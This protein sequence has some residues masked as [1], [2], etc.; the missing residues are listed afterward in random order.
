[1]RILSLTLLALFFAGCGP[2]VSEAYRKTAQYRYEVGEDA[3]E[4]GNYLEAVTH[5]S[6]VKT[7]FPY[8]KFAAL[9]ELRIGDAYFEQD[10]FVEAIDV[11]QTFVRRRPKHPKLAYAYWRIA[12]GYF[13]QMPADFFLFPPSFE[14]DRIYTKDALAAYVQY[15]SRFPDG[16]YAK[17]AGAKRK[18][19]RTKLGD[20]E[21][22]VARFYLKNER[23]MSAMGRLETVHERFRDIPGHWEEGSLELLNVYRLLSQ[24]DSSGEIRLL[25]AMERARGVAQTLIDNKPG[26]K[27]ASQATRYMAALNRGDDPE[28]VEVYKAKPMPKPPRFKVTK[29]LKEAAEDIK[30]SAKEAVLD[31]LDNT[32]KN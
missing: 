18:F 19:C 9:A 28:A 7:K 6:R 12:E 26:S 15:L 14:R 1:M 29:K 4:S 17:N 24:P 5:Y 21:L 22:Y 16:Q 30:E 13:E 11:Y 3:F 32:K 31:E 20:Y 2:A 10:K 27:A 25:D 8:S 23:P